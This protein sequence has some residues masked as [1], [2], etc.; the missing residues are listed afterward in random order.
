MS[1]YL[2]RKKQM[3]E[4]EGRK[5]VKNIPLIINRHHILENNKQE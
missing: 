2:E 3:R 5:L 4:E 1:A